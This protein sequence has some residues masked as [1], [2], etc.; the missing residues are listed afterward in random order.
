MTDEEFNRRA[1]E[2]LRREP[3]AD[4]LAQFLRLSR[5]G[6]GDYTGGQD[7]LLRKLSL[8]DLLQSIFGESTPREWR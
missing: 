1:P 2:L 3:G 5:S 6:S 4:G 8:D 7:R